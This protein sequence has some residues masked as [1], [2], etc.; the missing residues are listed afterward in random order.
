MD[1]HEARVMAALNEQPRKQLTIA[2]LIDSTGDNPAH[3]RRAVKALANRG[4][5]AE[6]T[7]GRPSSWQMSARGVS[8]AKTKRGHAVLDVPPIG[9]AR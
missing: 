6:A 7:R 3:V 4:L 8:F 2:E 1:M 5:L 9:V